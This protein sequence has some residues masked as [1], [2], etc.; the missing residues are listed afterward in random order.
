MK[1]I[2]LIL[3][4][5]STISLGQVGIG[6]ETPD[7]SS[8][9]DITSTTAGILVPRMLESE[10]TAIS[11]PATGLL[12]YQTDGAAGFWYYSG[13]TWTSLSAPAGNSSWELSGNS[14]TSPSTDFIGTT[15]A[16][17]IVI[18]RNN[19]FS[20]II[21]ATNTGLGYL[22]LN[23][24][25]AG[26]GNTAVGHR[27][28]LSITNASDNTAIGY[29]ALNDNES[30][31]SNTAVGSAALRDNI[32]GFGNVAIGRSSLRSNTSGLFNVAIGEGALRDSETID[33]NVAIGP[34]AMR[35]VTSGEYNISIGLESMEN[36]SPGNDNISMGRYS[37]ENAAGGDENIAIG[38]SSMQD[39]QGGG[40]NIGIGR[41]SLQNNVS[42]DHNIA[43]GQ[44][45]MQNN[46]A[47]TDNVAIGV[48]ALLNN[49]SGNRNTASGYGSL[50]NLTTGSNNAAFG[51][52]SGP[53]SSG[54]GLSNTIALGYQARPSSNN[55]ARIGNNTVSSI[56]GYANWSNV[57]DGRF[58][59]NIQENIKG[60]DFILKL[61]PVTYN[62]DMDAIAR[63]NK[64][65]D[66]LRL[67]KAE[68]LKGSEIQ[69][70]FIA[71]E[72]ERAAM[73]SG[74]DFHGV[75]KPKNKN[76]HYGL[77]YAEFVV[78]LVRAIQEQQQIIDN[79]NSKIEVLEGRLL[80]LERL[81]SEED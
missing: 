18:K 29:Y 1:K 46:Q 77:R 58:K 59:T 15:D 2:A 25:F 3:L 20:G 37:L 22:S 76:S 16:Q 5:V 41:S 53:L 79:Q 56:G 68:Q 10:R 4:L 74:F 23:N 28:L 9:L 69:N 52:G 57:S 30:G 32:S 42:G 50:A 72:V 31:S 38:N 80:R 64:V 7:A 26:D 6:T 55:S 44:S 65:P 61:R 17:D 54:S 36:A 27:A 48:T 73:E 39:I 66:S 21:G 33:R 81:I 62:L 63:F 45:S 14:G 60:L 78:P 49:S 8:A 71:Q 75:D 40:G 11:N 47:G 43:L 12:V 35:N 34:S 51:Y 24:S 67:R 13:S 19:Q 70:G